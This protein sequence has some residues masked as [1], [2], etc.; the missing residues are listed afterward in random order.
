MLLHILRMHREETHTCT[1][2]RDATM[3]I[4]FDFMEMFGP[5]L[6]VAG[7]IFW[8]WMLID[9]LNRPQARPQRGWLFLLILFTQ[10]VGA[11]IYFLIYVFPLSRV[12]HSTLSQSQSAQKKPFVYYTP[13]RP[14]AQTPP[15]YQEYQ[16]GYQPRTVPTPAPTQTDVPYYLQEDSQQTSY[17]TPDYEEPRATYPEMP[18]QQQ[19]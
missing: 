17:P 5:L 7:T 3:P 2:E 18:P 9:C 10:W 8:V 13:P 15:S 19:L 14:P 6:G 11:L 4:M 12:F 16:Q 1:D